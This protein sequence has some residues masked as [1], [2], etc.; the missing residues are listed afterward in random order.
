MI[1][2]EKTSINGVKILSLNVFN[3]KR[4]Y[5][6]ETFNKKEFDS[7]NINISKFVQDNE[8]L[9][10]FGVLRGI[11]FQTSPYEQSKLVR[12]IS[13]EI[14][15]VV[16]DLRKESSTYKKHISIMLN[17]NDKKQVY[18]PK[19]CAHAFLT[20]SKEAIV[21]Y[22]VDSYY[23]VNHQ[24]GIKYDDPSLNIKWLLEKKHIRLSDKD[25]QLEYL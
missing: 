8:S 24:S 22:K 11:H 1:N 6:F 17:E 10:K 20:L 18:I 23:S 9:S 2:V 16:V 3:D 7:V 5:F 25:K 19:G 4:G 15:D 21:A 13:G 12:V 14:Q